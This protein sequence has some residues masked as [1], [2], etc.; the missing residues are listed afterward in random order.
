MK[1]KLFFVTL[2]ASILCVSQPI[3]A[4]TDSA[5]RTLLRMVGDTISF[6]ANLEIFVSLNDVRYAD[7]DTI[8]IKKIKNKSKAID[9]KHFYTRQEIVRKEYIIGKQFYVLDVR[10]QKRLYSPENIDVYLLDIESKKIIIWSYKGFEN[11]YTR[12]ISKKLNRNSLSPDDDLYY[13]NNQQYAKDDYRG[14]TQ[15]KCVESISYYQA[16]DFLTEKT[17][18]TLV[19]FLGGNQYNC[20][21]KNMVISAPEFA[22]RKIRTLQ[23]LKSEGEYTFVLSKIEKPKNQSIRYGE[24]QEIASKYLYE[25]NVI[26]IL[27]F[28]TR[29]E[30]VFLLKNNSDNSLK[31]VWDEASFI[32]ENNGASRIVHKGVNKARLNEMQPPTVVP[33]G[34]ELNDIIVPVDR[35][36][37][38]LIDSIGKHNP[39]RDGQNVKVLLPVEIKGVVNEYIFTFDLVWKYKY[40]ELQ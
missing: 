12:I 23:K 26:S 25:D 2:F 20:S 4:V 37:K 36:D 7:I 5:K 8:W 32:N 34:T 33:K 21:D 11:S 10:E 6:S 13:Y 24:F 16:D 18:M 19:D 35:I 31:I 38:N 15:V 39:E 28:G 30:F 3:W 40:P 17:L 14:Y 27:W 29:E 22:Q 1:N 9:G